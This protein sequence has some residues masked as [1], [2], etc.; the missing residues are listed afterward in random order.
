MSRHTLLAAAA[1]A[2][3]VLVMV[4]SGVTAE[5]RW[6][7]AN[8]CAREHGGCVGGPHN[9]CYACVD[10]C[11]HAKWDYNQDYKTEKWITS[12]LK[13]CAKLRDGRSSSGGGESKKHVKLANKCHTRHAKCYKS[14]G[15]RTCKKCVKACAKALKQGLKGWLFDQ[16]KADYKDCEDWA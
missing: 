6:K 10:D 15:K 5:P 3:L 9:D 4:A 1:T 8:R 2:A 14:H 16:V 7:A 13:E 12:N 11:A